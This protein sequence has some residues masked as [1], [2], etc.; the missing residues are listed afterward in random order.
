MNGLNKALQSIDI[1]RLQA[2]NQIEKLYY[3][4]HELLIITEKDSNKNFYDDETENMDQSI[5]FRIPDQAGGNTDSL[6]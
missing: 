2:I 1:D 4:D 3:H 5:L 6:T